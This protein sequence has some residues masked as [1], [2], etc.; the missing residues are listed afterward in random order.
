MWNNLFFVCR[1][2]TCPLQQW[3]IDESWLAIVAVGGCS[4]PLSGEITGDVIQKTDTAIYCINFSPE[5]VT[6]RLSSSPA[7]KSGA[8]GP[9]SGQLR[10]P[11]GRGLFI[12][13]NGFAMRNWRERN[14]DRQIT[15]VSVFSSPSLAPRTG[16][17]WAIGPPEN[18]SIGPKY[19]PENRT[20]SSRPPTLKCTCKSYENTARYFPSS[21]RIT[22]SI[23]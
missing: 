4:P 13:A 8:E 7:P 23:Y 6:P 5:T 22:E 19:Y 12:R 11:G 3:F 1:G 10:E 16:M 14:A 18:S 17:S 2:E 9:D 21:F 20:N 15:P